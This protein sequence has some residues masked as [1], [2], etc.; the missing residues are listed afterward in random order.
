LA[1]ATLAKQADLQPCGSAIIGKISKENLV[2][3]TK[4][5]QYSYEEYHRVGCD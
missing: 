5:A 4:L 3:K 1:E 2:E